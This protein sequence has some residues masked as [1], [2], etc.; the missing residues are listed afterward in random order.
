MDIDL[1]VYF[2]L[3]DSIPSSQSIISKP[4]PPWHLQEAVPS[5]IRPASSRYHK[6]I[7]WSYTTRASPLIC[8]SSLG[9]KH[10]NVG[11][12]VNELNTLK[13]GAGWDPVGR[14]GKPMPRICASSIKMSYCSFH[15]GRC[16]VSILCHH[17]TWDDSILGALRWSLLLAEWQNVHE[18]LAQLPLG[19]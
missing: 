11:F 19:G 4:M 1:R 12:C 13:A 7:P 14:K 17:V 10:Y 5:P 9:L 2:I 8:I 18:D 3:E 16:P 6:W 15:N